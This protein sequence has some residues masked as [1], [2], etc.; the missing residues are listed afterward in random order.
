M[1]NIDF[2]IAG[3]KNETENNKD[4][5]T[6]TFNRTKKRARAPTPSTLKYTTTRNTDDIKSFVDIFRVFFNDDKY[7]PKT[8]MDI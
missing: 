6:Q 2:D 8:T 7:Q 4:K 5:F 1:L 3:T